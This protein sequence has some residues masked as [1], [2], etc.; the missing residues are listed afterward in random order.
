VSGNTS[1]RGWGTAGANG[2]TCTFNLTG[3]KASGD[4]LADSI[5]K[6]T[7]RIADGSTYTGA[8]NADGTEAAALSVTLDSTST[9]TLTGDSY[10]TQ[11]DGD[12]ANVVADGHTLYVH[13]SAAN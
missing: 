1:E 13:R 12:M 8:V 3:Q 9:W 10:V 2:G 5:S 6:L 4:I 11:F 7:M